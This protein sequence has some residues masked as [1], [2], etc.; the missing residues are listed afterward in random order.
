[1]GDRTELQHIDLPTLMAISS[2]FPFSRVA[3]PGLS[4]GCWLSLPH[5]VSKLS[6][7]QTDFLSS[8]SYMIVRNTGTNEVIHS[9]G[10]LWG[11]IEWA[12]E[13]SYTLRN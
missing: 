10:Q 9:N 12:I 6:D 13:L 7:L 8:P 4:A 11:D 3:Q 1:M 2:S 5:L